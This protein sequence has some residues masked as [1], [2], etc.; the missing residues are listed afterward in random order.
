[1]GKALRH[2]FVSLAIV[3]AVVAAL[4]GASVMANAGPPKPVT[5]RTGDSIPP[6][7]EG[8]DCNLRYVAGGDGV[9]K[10]TDNSDN[11]YAKDLLEDKLQKTPGPWC[12]WNTSD[13]P[14][15][16]DNYIHNGQQSLAWDLDP[17]L[18]TLTLGRQN[19]VIINHVKD[20]LQNIK[21]H[22]F[23]SANTCA[24]TVLADTN[25]WDTLTNDLSN[26]MQQYKVQQDGDPRLVVAVT[27]YFNPYPSATDVATK[28]PSFC[29]DLI[30]V[31]PTCLARWLLLPPAL[32][33]L[34]QV[35]QKLN[36][37]ISDVVAQF[38]QAT[39]GRM[40]FV[41]PYD[42]FKD[43]CTK[44]DVLITITVYH[45]PSTVDTHNTDADKS[46]GCSS[47]WIASDGNDGTLTP[48]PYLSPA[49][50]GVLLTAIQD[51]SGMGINPNDTG[52]KCI[53]L[54]IWEAVKQKLR[55]AEAPVSDPCS[56]L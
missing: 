21:D 32:V 8:S 25:A 29:A 19:N 24:L 46:F 22:D 35:V 26:I 39:Q 54:L 23:I 9:V 13:D 31:I 1:M 47:P 48:F 7:T 40:V 38:T 6:P 33:T 37:T 42:A 10:G 52:H 34:D 45:P 44:M 11:S 27:G 30:D 18:I 36:T 28:I 5:I 20:C 50:N 17:R 56:S 16:T 51:T 53:S 4:V 55:V 2:P 49:V 12:L 43:H 41:N 3:V 14:V 15:T